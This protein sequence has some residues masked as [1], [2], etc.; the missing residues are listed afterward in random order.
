MQKENAI[1]VGLRFVNPI[2]TEP[3]MKIQKKLLLGFLS[4]AAIILVAGILGIIEIRTI[5]VQSENIGMINAPLS[6]A[7][8]EIKLTATTAHL[9]FEEILTGAE[10]KMVI[11][12]VWK[13]IDESLWYCNAILHGG[14]NTEGHFYPVNDKQIEQKILS[15]QSDLREFQQLAKLRFENNF[16]NKKLE[17]QALDDKFDAL[18]NQFIHNADEAETMIHAKMDKDA[19]QID[20]TV[21]NSLWILSIATFL[22]FIVA[23]VLGIKISYTISKPIQEAVQLASSVAKGDFSQQFNK[24]YMENRNDEIRDLFQALSI[25]MKYMILFLNI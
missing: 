14:R 18:F 8:M 2:Y 6:D 4:I 23:V 7:V 11:A 19:Q 12:K 21:T 13:L 3:I 17:D 22:S 15:V 1:N 24:K 20:N 9:W 10:E 5:H 16:G 25:M